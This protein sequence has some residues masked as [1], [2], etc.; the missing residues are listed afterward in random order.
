MESLLS[1]V[2]PAKLPAAMAGT[3][4]LRV[5]YPDGHGVLR[6]LLNEATQRGFTIDDL[7]V[8]PVGERSRASGKG[9]RDGE[10]APGVMHAGG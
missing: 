7:P 2:V 6:R 3:S 1:P 9:E 5:R 8:E 10:P 4:T